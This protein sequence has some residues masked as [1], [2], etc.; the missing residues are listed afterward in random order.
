[1]DNDVKELL[2]F[3]SLALLA[4]AGVAFVAVMALLHG[5]W[6]AAGGMACAAVVGGLAAAMAVAPRWRG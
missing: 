2:V 4:L 3:G 5:G 1:M 6:W